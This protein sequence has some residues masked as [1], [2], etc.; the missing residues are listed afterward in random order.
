[1]V[2]R[3]LHHNTRHSPETKK[4]RKINHRKSGRYIKKKKNTI[5]QRQG[6]LGYV[7]DFGDKINILDYNAFQKSEKQAGAS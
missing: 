5:T 1:M 3:D 2:Q 4:K 6:K 7:D